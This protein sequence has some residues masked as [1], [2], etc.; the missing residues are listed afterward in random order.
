MNAEVARELKTLPQDRVDPVAVE[1]V[2]QLADFLNLQEKLLRQS[3]EECREMA[4]LFAT[5]HAEGEAFDWDSPRGT[6]YERLE[7]ALFAKMK[8]TAA[9]EGAIDKRRLAELATRAKAASTALAQKYG[10]AFP[11]LLGN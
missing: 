7:A 3:G 10:R 11:D 4:T 1:C 8:Q 2:T 6:K 9:N 5:I